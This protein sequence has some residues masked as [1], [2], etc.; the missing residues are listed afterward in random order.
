MQV[1]FAKYALPAKGAVVVTVTEGLVLGKLAKDLDKKVQGALTRAIKQQDYKGKKGEILSLVAPAGTNYDAIVIAGLGQE[2]DIQSENIRKLGGKLYTALNSLRLKNASILIEHID[3]PTILVA[4][5][6]LGIQL[7]AYRFDKYK[8]QN[9]EKRKVY[10]SSITI[11]CETADKAT[12]E[13]KEGLDVVG[14]VYLAR[15]LVTEP[16]N[17][18]YP[19]SYANRIQKEL[20]PLG[21]KVKILDVKQ[22]QAEGMGALLGVGMGSVRDSR[23]VVMEWIGDK[24]AQKSKKQPLGFVGKGVTFDTG[25]ISIKPAQNM[26]DMKYDMAG[27]A[28]VVGLMKTVAMRKL[29]ENVVGVVGLVE[30]MPSG[31]AQRPGDVVT[32]MSGK[33]IE[34]LNTDAEGRLVLADAL[35]YIQK[36]YTPRSIVNLATLTGAIVISLGSDHAGLFSNNNELSEHLRQAGVETD[37]KL[38][39]LPMG[40]V[41]DRLIDSPIAD[42][43][44]ISLDRGAGS[45]T[46][47]QFLKRFI[48]NDTPWAH[49]DIAGM[50]WAE[51]E[52]DICPKGATGFGVRLLYQFIKD[53]QN[54]KK[55]NKG[56]TI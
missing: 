47:A 29:K 28:V 18:L 10:L 48:E 34:V 52:R 46:A 9:P 27:S 54:F 19:E 45:I 32:S 14:G 38:W 23:L 24:A 21:V 5:M 33:T 35:T 37:E 56:K 53:S 16:S 31:N 22:M 20:T 25:G 40:N 49:L 44:N 55:A 15:D 8:T 50:A 6:G 30:N 3:K 12:A 7:K 36:Y 39:R 42:M 13:Y 26:W 4:Q 51:R 2:K 43:Q 17:V 11:C 1:T 41:Y